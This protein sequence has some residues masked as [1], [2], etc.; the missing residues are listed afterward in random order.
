MGSGLQIFRK[1][2]L[3]ITTPANCAENNNPKA[4]CA[5]DNNS[6]FGLKV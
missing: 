4:N 5:A 1:N 3:P 2:V 6:Y